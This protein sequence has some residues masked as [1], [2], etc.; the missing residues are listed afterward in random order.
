MQEWKVDVVET[1]EEWWDGL[2]ENEQIEISAVVKLLRQMGPTLGFPYSFGIE[3]AKY[4]HMREL[5]IQF[6][7][8]P[9]RIL[10]AF[11]PKRTAMLLVGGNKT[12]KDRWYKK[13]VPIADKLFREHLKTLDKKGSN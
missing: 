6:K 9:Y 1:F 4:S 10:Y 11:D 8:K 2:T 12:G 13:H 3:G 5:R 7:G